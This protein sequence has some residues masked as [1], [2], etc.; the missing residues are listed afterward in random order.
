MS[1]QKVHKITKP[2]KMWVYDFGSDSVRGPLKSL[3]AVAHIGKL[4]CAA[5]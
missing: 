1:M 4:M 3:I 5:T 2:E